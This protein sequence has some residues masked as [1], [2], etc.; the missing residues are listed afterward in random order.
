MK[1]VF[2]CSALAFG[3]LSASGQTPF[4]DS[5]FGI[6]GRQTFTSIAGTK[7][8]SAIA[9]DTNDYLYAGSTMRAVGSYNSSFMITKSRPDGTPDNT[10]GNLGTV[11]SN[12]DTAN[13][14][15]L[16]A[17][18][19]TRNQ[20]V[21]AGGYTTVGTVQNALLVRYKANG[22]LDSAFGVNGSVRA[23]RGTYT[24]INAL[25]VQSDDK[26]I[27]VGANHTSKTAI[28]AAR[29]NSDGSPDNSFGV[30]G[31]DTFHRAANST[32]TVVAVQIQP[33]GK[34]VIAGMS[35]G[36]GMML[37]RLNTN[38]T[39]DNTFGVNGYTVFVN[40]L[41]L[42]GTI[43]DM[44]TLPDGSILTTDFRTGSFSSMQPFVKK[45]SVD[46][47]LSTTYNN[48][49]TTG[50]PPDWGMVLS[51]VQFPTSSSATIRTLAAAP[52]G[53]L[54]CAG[55]FQGT[56]GNQPMVVKL[57]PSGLLDSAFGVDGK[58]VDDIPGR[59][60]GDVLIQ[61]NGKIVAGVSAGMPVTDYA[62][63]RYTN[64]PLYLGPDAAICPEGEGSITLDARNAGSSYLWS[65]GAT[66]QTI[67][68]SDSGTYSVRVTNSKGSVTDSIHIGYYPRPLV[69]LGNDTTICYGNT[70]TL[71][72]QN[73]GAAYL[74]SN[75][76]TS[77]TI[78]V[79]SNGLYSVRVTNSYQ[80]VG[81]DTIQVTV[82]PSPITVNLGA[83]TAFCTGNSLTLNAQNAGAAYL[84]NNG[85]TTQTVDVAT[86]GSYSVIV[87]DANQCKAFDTV[88][89]TVNPL[90]VVSLGNDTTF[91]AGNILDAGNAGAFFLWNTGATTQTIPV[92]VSGSYSVTVTD[93]NTCSKSDTVQVTAEPLPVVDLGSDTLRAANGT[94]VTLDAGSAGVSYVWSDG[95]NTQLH[96]VIN[97]AWYRVVV[98]GANGCSASDSV[99]V[100]FGVLGI[101]SPEI[102]GHITISPNPVTE[103][104]SIDIGELK[105]LMHTPVTISDAMGRIVKT[106][107]IDQKIQPCSLAGLP[108]GIYFL[109]TA[110][111]S[112]KIVKR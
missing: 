96:N 22:T 29:Y 48:A 6:N 97:T 44:V 79:S 55:A 64:I 67:T 110:Y 61:K 35:I 57:K 70:I 100:Y 28:W 26:I 65:T 31:S 60:I 109:R 53:G 5:S 86:S 75:S 72:A 47:V 15:Y 93:G 77:Q 90:P 36:G 34:I 95:G 37:M 74:W 83:D 12:F 13:R 99:Y 52:D 102:T 85:A 19:V 76:A 16:K 78:N 73:T 25:A 89:I 7:F 4:L 56:G 104:M 111:G 42:G 32:D 30:N 94:V 11:I 87:T 3:V 18:A 68:V 39:L 103:M 20:K 46:G 21:I 27:A 92:S 54:I 51:L 49:G 17:I 40:S 98:T 14:D 106:V 24:H 59:S 88:Q 2:L 82:A 108:P 41:G 80:C 71:N 8:L 63:Y 33:G 50:S 91:C 107:I 84:W 112:I 69:Q 81:R 10:F 62:L 66:T 45:F 43:A 101:Q 105:A 23:L 1:K 9:A 58:I 38:G